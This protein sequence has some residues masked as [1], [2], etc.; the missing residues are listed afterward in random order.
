MNR[1]RQISIMV[2]EQNAKMALTHAHFGYVLE[3]G[4]V[5]IEDTC[6]RLMQ[7]DDIK[8]F[9]LGMQADGRARRAA[10]EAQ[11]DVAM[12]LVATLA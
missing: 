8:E 2:V 1:E 5:V 10:L 9:Y 11:E 7:N 6:E 4:R 12:N 3:L